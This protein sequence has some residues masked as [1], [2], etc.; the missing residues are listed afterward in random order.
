MQRGGWGVFSEGG[1]GD[2]AKPG[3]GAVRK[4]LEEHVLPKVKGW[5]WALRMEAAFSREEVNKPS[6]G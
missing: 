5:T 6:L 3:A 4:R 2:S 1:P